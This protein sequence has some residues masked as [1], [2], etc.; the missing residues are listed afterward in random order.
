VYGSIIGAESG[1][2]P[3][4][5]NLF[6]S[7]APGGTWTNP[8]APT[9]SLNNG[10]GLDSRS[11]LFD[12]YQGTLRDSIPETDANG[13]ARA[14]GY[15]TPPSILVADPDTGVLRYVKMTRESGMLVGDGNDGRFGYGQGVYVDNIDDRQIPVDEPGRANIG[16][17][18]SLIYDWLNPN[19]G[20]SNSGWQGPFYVP[21]GAYLRLLSDGFTITR[22]SRASAGRRTWKNPDGSDSG[23]TTIRYRFGYARDG[24]GK[25][26]RDASGKPILYLVNTYSPFI[27]G[28]SINSPTADQSGFID[29]SVGQPFNGVLYFEGNVRVR[30]QIPT[31]VPMLVVSNGTIYIEGS[32]TKGVVGND[33]TFRQ[34]GEVDADQGVTPGLLI[35]TPP[36]GI[37]RLSHSSIGLFAKDYVALNTTQFFGPDPNQTLE[38]V[39]DV[40]SA[41][42]F[43]P[44][45]VRNPGNSLTF[46]SELLL[47]RDPVTAL[48]PGGAADVNNPS[49]WKPF[50]TG[51]TDAGGAGAISQD[52]ILTHTMDD[53]PAPNTFFSLNVNPGLVNA[54]EPPLPGPYTAPYPTYLFTESTYNS[55]STY[56]PPSYVTPG[57]TGASTGYLPMYGLGSETWQR[58]S[59][60]ESTNFPIFDS[61][62]TYNTDASFL[63]DIAAPA[64]NGFYYGLAEETNQFQIYPNNV[65]SA[66]TNDYLLAR[67]ALVPNDIRIDAAIFAEEGSFFVIPGNW[68]NP[69]PNDTRDNYASFG[70]S[71]AE[72]QLARLESFGAGPSTPFYG[73]PIDVRVQI[74]GAVSE[75]MPPPIGQQAEGLKKWGWIPY[76]TADTGHSVAGA[77]VPAGWGRTDLVPNMT[78]TYDPML[79]TG[80][81]GGS[82]ANPLVR[83]DAYGRALPPLPRLPVSPVL[84]YFGEVN[85]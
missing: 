22:D 5:L 9:A 13:F 12:T 31:D 79:G 23:S 56:Y 51:Y 69:N 46:D 63:R 82:I 59:K 41:V 34:A 11:N 67:A 64:A 74:Y 37:P 33:F 48:N 80:R 72:R 8:A 30:G 3:S 6:V 50:G 2:N 57:F 43:P 25:A 29:Y 54:T 19:N 76:S 75:N 20:G 83:T 62:S 32:V 28:Q 38:E 81:A 27:P 70:A 36:S 84:A 40:P 77:H 60:F 85:P 24:T 1:A 16:S 17:S 42:G 39:M 26:I 58:Y 49:T 14:V 44:I 55:A 65:G 35:A 52:L 10:N 61:T 45:R 4:T 15:K 71:G 21:K 78:I 53:G 47:N 73:E 68:F 7:T 18:Q 66:P